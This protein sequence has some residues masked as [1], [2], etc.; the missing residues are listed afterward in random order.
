MET[1]PHIFDL[2]EAYLGDTL[3]EESR[4][5][6]ETRYQKESDFAALVDTYSRE[7]QVI[8][9]AGENDLKN[10]LN[11]RFKPAQATTPVRKLSFRPYIMA[12]A[13]AVVLLLSVFFFTQTADQQGTADLFAENFQAPNFVARSAQD[14]PE[15]LPWQEAAAY[16]QAGDYEKA[17]KALE[18]LVAT[19]VFGHF[20]EA[21][22]YLGVCYL[23]LEQPYKA[24]GALEKVKPGSVF[25]QNAQWFRLLSYLQLEDT[26]NAIKAAE[27]ILQVNR[28]YKTAEATKILQ[29]LKK[30]EST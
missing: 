16:Y 20:S 24:L 9:T 25:V 2:V 7:I 12:A 4:Q 15:E 6:F 27:A 17:A 8:Q 14:S 13:A 19:T 5:A 11:Q 22:L 3:D 30:F 1:N 21:Q 10:A 26:P 29:L 18:A 23:K 28:H